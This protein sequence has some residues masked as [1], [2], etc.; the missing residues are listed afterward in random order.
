MAAKSSRVVNA[1]KGKLIKALQSEP[2]FVGAGI[3]KDSDGTPVVVA[4]VETN[5]VQSRLNIPSELDGVPVRVE[6]VGRPRKH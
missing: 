3:G 6:V 1:A 5:I 2:G 4:L